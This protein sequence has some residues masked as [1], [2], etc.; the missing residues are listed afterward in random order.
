MRRRLQIQIGGTW[1]LVPDGQT[2][3]REWLFS[4]FAN[5][6]WPGRRLKY[7]AVPR[8]MWKPHLIENYDAGEADAR[9][10]WLTGAIRVLGLDVGAAIFF[11]PTPTTPV[12]PSSDGAGR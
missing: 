4:P 3:W 8:E 10:W 6:A 2:T 7:T 5:Y 11:D 9:F 12:Q 1:A